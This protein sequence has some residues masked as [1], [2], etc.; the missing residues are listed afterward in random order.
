MITE[1][2]SS[3]NLRETAIIIV[4]AYEDKLLAVVYL[5]WAAQNFMTK[6]EITKVQCIVQWLELKNFELDKIK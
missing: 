2:I 6:D 5:Q 4:N 3:A 1:V